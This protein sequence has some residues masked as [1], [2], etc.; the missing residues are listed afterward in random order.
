MATRK[1]PATKS[2]LK[3]KTAKGATRRFSW[4]HACLVVVVGAFTLVL[5]AAAVLY[6]MRDQ[7]TV[8]GD[9]TIDTRNAELDVAATS[10]KGEYVWREASYGE[11]LRSFLVADAERNLEASDSCAPLYYKI[12]HATADGQQLKVNYGCEEPN[13]FMFL[14]HDAD[15]WREISPT[16]QFDT[17]GTPRCDHVGAHNISREIAPVCWNGAT[18]GSDMT[19]VVR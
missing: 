6:T 14:V 17:F 16:N 10:E 1:A 18:D 13:A 3:S 7:L 5:T 9:Y 2:K 4:P 8:A 12:T 11:E 19:Y 15:G